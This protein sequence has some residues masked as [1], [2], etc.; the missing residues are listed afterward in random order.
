M[1]RI[2]LPVDLLHTRSVYLGVILKR[3]R[4]LVAGGL[5]LFQRG[6]SEKEH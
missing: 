1:M 3:S 6:E 2:I 4:I 5:S